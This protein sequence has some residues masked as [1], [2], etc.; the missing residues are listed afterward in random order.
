MPNVASIHSPAA[1]GS[2]EPDAGTTA[3]GA[4]KVPKSSVTTASMPLNALRI[5]IIAVVT[6]AMTN[7]EIPEI[8]WVRLLDRRTQA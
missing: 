5:A 7:M 1:A 8:R 2:S 3:R 4:S 6:A